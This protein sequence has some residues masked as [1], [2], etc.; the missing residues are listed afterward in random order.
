MARAAELMAC[1]RL[2]DK[3]VAR[4]RPARPKSMQLGH[5]FETVVPV[6]LMRRPLLLLAFVLLG[7]AL[8]RAFS[9][10]TTPQVGS[11]VG[12]VSAELSDGEVFSLAGHRGR[13]V[14]VNFWA[15]WCL[16]CRQEIPV[17]NMLRD[18]GIEIVGLAVDPLSLPEIGRQALALGIRYPVGKGAAGLAERLGVR[19][20]P[21]TYVIDP[22]GV[23]VLARA[24]VVESAEISAAVARA[25]TP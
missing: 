4:G 11:A 23:L 12:D 25:Q 15:T 3:A 19:A 17:L 9:P 14:V 10:E 5:H 7:W 1:A 22:R 16:P 2:V 20:V 24:G 8:L 6:L 21:S 18:R 13:V